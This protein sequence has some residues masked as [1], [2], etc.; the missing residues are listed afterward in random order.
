MHELSIAQSLVEMVIRESEARGFA[1]V[2]SVKVRVGG[3]AHVEPENLKF[4]YRQFSKGTG[5][6]GS[7]LVVEKRPVTVSC[8]HCGRKFEVVESSFVCPECDIADVNLCSGDELILE[9]MEV[10]D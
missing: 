6:E 7:E 8:K 4:W 1:R 10:E 3:L 5:V 9:G 2:V